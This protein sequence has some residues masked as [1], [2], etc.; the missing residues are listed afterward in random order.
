MADPL[1]MVAQACLTAAETDSLA[2]PEIVG[3]LVDSGFEGYLTDF[4]RGVTTYYL[5]DGDCIDLPMH[6][7]KTPIGETFD[8]ATILEAIRAAQSRADGYTY[9]GFCTGITA[10][11]C[12]GYLVSF[13]GERVVYF[14]RTGE[15]HVEHFPK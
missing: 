9:A 3:R 8:A 14:G 10:A 12:A 11:G 4:R 2:F 1:R 13:P 15:T 7:G 5:P 6:I